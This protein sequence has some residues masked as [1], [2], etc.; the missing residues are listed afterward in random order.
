MRL[1]VIGVNHKSADLA[2]RERVARAA[3]ERL[4]EKPLVLLSTCNRTEIYFSSALT[5]AE[6]HSQ[7]LALLRGSAGGGFEHALYSYFGAEA[8]IHLSLVTTGLDSALVGE[9][10]IQGQVKTAYELAQIEHRLAAPLHLAFQKALH[11]G[12][13]TRCQFPTLNGGVSLEATLLALSA[14]IC[15]TLPSAHIFF[16]GNSAINRQ[17]IAHFQRRGLVHMTL[18]TRTPQEAE[19]PHVVDWSKLSLW[20]ECEVVIC[21]TK[22]SVPIIGPEQIGSHCRTQLLCDLSM[23]RAVDARLGA[24]P[25]INL[26]NIE[27]ISSLCEQKSSVHRLDIERAVSF[28]QRSA[29][30]L[31]E[32]R[33]D[34]VQE[35]AAI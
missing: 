3:S 32:R 5:L 23:P 20:Q 21:A 11:V 27:Q 13:Q 28:V 12:K 19:A 31:L 10:E 35:C 25:Q 7:L 16:L 4:R 22:L 2:V 29:E 15:P 34:K 6:E 8:F 24:H 30:K 17:I 9:S 1:G 33:L 18:C 26:F 14:W